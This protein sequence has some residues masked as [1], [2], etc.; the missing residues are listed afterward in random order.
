MSIET[1]HIKESVYTQSYIVEILLKRMF[2]TFNQSFVYKDHLL[3]MR[4]L[5]ISDGLYTFMIDCM[6]VDLV[7]KIGKHIMLLF[8]TH[9]FIR[10]KLIL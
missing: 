2:N 5:F 7:T 10:C 4:N 6:H 3:P 9:V 8:Q 1:Q